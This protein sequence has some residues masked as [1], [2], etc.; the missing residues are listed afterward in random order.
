MGANVV[1]GRAELQNALLRALTLSHT[2]KWHGQ[3]SAREEVASRRGAPRP[4]QDNE[5]GPSN[6]G[7]AIAR[8]AGRW[9]K[10]AGTRQG[11][12]MIAESRQ[13]LGQGFLCI[14][15]SSC[16][17][18]ML[19]ELLDRFLDGIHQLQLRSSQCSACCPTK[20]LWRPVPTRVCVR[21]ACRLPAVAVPLV[22]WGKIRDR[23]EG[24][25][26]AVARAVAV[27]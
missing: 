24:G 25:G 11:T 1:V 3:T 8:R 2:N 19:C 16:A 18:G 20:R 22:H 13:V 7:A 21:T 10:P 15:F 26:V 12:G 9:P 5:D 23:G 4:A 6:S 14:F 17:Q 27:K